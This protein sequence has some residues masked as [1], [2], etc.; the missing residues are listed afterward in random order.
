MPLSSDGVTGR[1]VRTSHAHTR[2]QGCRW[3]GE[4]LSGLWFR[5][6]GLGFRVKG[7]GFKRSTAR[8]HSKVQAV[9]V[10]DV[11]IEPAH[12]VTDFLLRR[13]THATGVW[14]GRFTKHHR[15]STGAGH[16]TCR[17]SIEPVHTHI[18]VFVP[19]PRG[20]PGGAQAHYGAL[21]VKPFTL[22]PATYT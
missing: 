10:L 9:H 7:L 15:F 13:F 18:Q 11:L 5:V 3:N 16:F 4:R 2:L 6:Q 17:F 21:A 22:H 1:H 19:L 8:G 20:V 12:T 14:L